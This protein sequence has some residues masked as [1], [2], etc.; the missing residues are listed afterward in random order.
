MVGLIEAN[1]VWTCIEKVM[2]AHMDDLNTNA[3]N[4]LASVK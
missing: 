4:K 3:I 2:T 1:G